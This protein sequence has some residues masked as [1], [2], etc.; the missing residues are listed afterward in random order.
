MRLG[1][2]EVLIT[3]GT[4]AFKLYNSRRIY[5]RHRHRYE[6]NLN[7]IEELEKHGLLFSGKSPDGKRMEILELPT[8]TFHFATQF[9]PEFKSRPGKPSPPYYGVH[10]GMRKEVKALRLLSLA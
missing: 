3:P 2:H 8:Q 9:H 10:K 1:A 5:E 6:I 4:L 7:Y